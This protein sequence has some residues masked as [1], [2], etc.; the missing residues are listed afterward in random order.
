MY[1]LGKKIFDA[2]KSLFGKKDE[3]AETTADQ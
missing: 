1:W 3:N 2:I